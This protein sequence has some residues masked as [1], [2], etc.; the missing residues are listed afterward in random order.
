[1][2]LEQI[3]K[4]WKETDSQIPM[5][6]LDVASVESTKLH[7]KYLELYANAKL[8]LKDA[9]FKQKELMKW[10]YLYYEGKMSK[11]DMDRFGWAYDPYEGL[12]ATTN[13]FKEH[14]V[15]TD[16]E[17]VESEAR[18]EY[19]KNCIDT[20]KDIMENLKWR[21]QTIRNAIEWKKFEAGF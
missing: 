8:K 21:H 15:E 9:E 3:L 7:G 2:N 1:M 14:F 10:K 20:L 12:S 6:A 16:K 5:N 17:L 13:K 18:I 4:V 11:E 19:L